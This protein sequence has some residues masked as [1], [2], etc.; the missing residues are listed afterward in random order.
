MNRLY[1]GHIYTFWIYIPFLIETEENLTMTNFH[2]I[3]VV[4]ILFYCT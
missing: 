3:V 2:L 4:A 1:W